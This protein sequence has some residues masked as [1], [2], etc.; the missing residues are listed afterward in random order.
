M[1]LIDPTKGA[2]RK[3]NDSQKRKFVSKGGRGGGFTQ[4]TVRGGWG[5]L[6]KNVHEFPFLS[7]VELFERSLMKV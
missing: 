1:H 6:R 2:F 7:F 3:F 5:G 4:F